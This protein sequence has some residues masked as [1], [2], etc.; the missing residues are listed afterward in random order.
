MANA[1]K[2]GFE[3]PNKI[4]IDEYAKNVG[5]DPGAMNKIYSLKA[6]PF[7]GVKLL[8]I[9]A[10]SSFTFVIVSL[11]ISIGLFLGFYRSSSFLSALRISLIPFASL[12]IPVGRWVYNKFIKK[13]YFEENMPKIK[14]NLE[15]VRT[16][17]FGHTH[18]PDIRKVNDKFWYVNSGTWTTVFSE[19]ERIIREAKQ[20]A[21]VRI[22]DANKM[23][24]LL[25]WNPGLKEHQRLILFE[26]EQKKRKG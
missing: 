16:I 25:R 3:D 11:V 26:P 23:P 6:K 21:F 15:H 13:D 22:S 1:K 19:E 12:I 20:F 8:N 2:G 5:L 14:E 9:L 4:K 24:E 7:S 17:V 10:F 18:N